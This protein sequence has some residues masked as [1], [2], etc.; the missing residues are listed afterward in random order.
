MT[1]GSAVE[2]ANW[3]EAALAEGTPIKV[4]NT[5]KGR[6]KYPEGADSLTPVPDEVADDATD[7]AS[8]LPSTP[9]PA[10]TVAAT[11]AASVD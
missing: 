2:S 1:R 9:V 4:Q 6:I 8:G 7:P 5:D 10:A 11:P 3:R